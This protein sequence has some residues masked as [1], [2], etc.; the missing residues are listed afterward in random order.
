M[1]ENRFDINDI[2]LKTLHANRVLLHNLFDGSRSHSR[3]IENPTFS[4]GKVFKIGPNIKTVVLP[5]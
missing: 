4:Q 1:Q 5:F 3:I 2:V